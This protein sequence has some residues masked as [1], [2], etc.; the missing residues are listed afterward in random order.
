MLIFDVGDFM[1]A[2]ENSDIEKRDIK[3]IDTIW[4]VKNFSLSML[5]FKN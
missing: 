1:D 5:Q 3:R 2:N 4:E